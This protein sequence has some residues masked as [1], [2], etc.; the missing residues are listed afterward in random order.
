MSEPF[1]TADDFRVFGIENPAR[2][3]AIANSKIAPLIQ[4]L[5]FYTE[6]FTWARV[7]ADFRSG[8]DTAYGLNR[9]YGEQA[10]KA[11]A[12]SVHPENP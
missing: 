5:E 3:S 8:V 7:V 1:F 6:T 9:M 4:A 10:R 12:T 11:L 2:A